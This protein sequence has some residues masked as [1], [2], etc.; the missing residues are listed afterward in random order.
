MSIYA[1]FDYPPQPDAREFLD[2]IQET[3]KEKE[4]EL[5]IKDLFCL[6]IPESQEAVYYSCG[7]DALLGELETSLLK[8]AIVNEV[9]S[10]EDFVKGVATEGII[11]GSERWFNKEKSIFL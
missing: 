8:R 4:K 9:I 3:L 2:E 6:F 11:L 5:R 1:R 7:E 10:K